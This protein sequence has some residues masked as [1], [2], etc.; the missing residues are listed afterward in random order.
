MH[1]REALVTLGINVAAIAG[2][3]TLGGVC[4]LLLNDGLTHEQRVEKRWQELLTPQGNVVR[5]EMAS[6]GLNDWHN[7]VRFDQ[8]SEIERLVLDV[9]TNP[10]TF[11][12][13]KDEIVQFIVEMNQKSSSRVPAANLV[14]VRHPLSEITLTANESSPSPLVKFDFDLARLITYTPATNRL[15]SFTHQK[16]D[17]PKQYFDTPGL[18]QSVAIEG[19]TPDLLLQPAT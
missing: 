14:L 3:V 15:G 7:L 11:M 13:L 6:L 8:L 1:R 16:Y 2:I 4:T 9:D 19:S 17:N 10:P 18:I 5:A 12:Q